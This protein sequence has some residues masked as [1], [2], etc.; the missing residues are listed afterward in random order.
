[1][2]P[3]LELRH[4]CKRYGRGSSRRT[5]LD[6]ISLTLDAGELVTIWG[7]RRSGRSTLLRVAAGV[8]RPDAG[9]VR[10]ASA[11]SSSRA[12]A[13]LGEGIGYCRSSFPPAVGRLVR[14]QLEI[15]QLARGVPSSQAAARAEH[16][17]GRCQARQYAML[18]PAA[19]N[20]AE[21]VRVSIARA[22]ALQP[23]LIVIDEPTLDVDLLARDEILELLRSLA[24]EGIAVLTSAGD[25]TGLAGS[26]L[27][28]ALSGGRLHGQREPGRAEVLP[29]RA[30]AS[31]RARA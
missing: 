31:R 5:V 10:F 4:V 29:L 26:D 15:A 17:L 25:T 24:D 1:M 11:D 16:A 18:S 14:D 8:E 21:R 22:L 7:K 13:A 2:G 12:D 19:L 6:D 30:S 27:A 23:R 28:L 20:G 3:L 9:Y